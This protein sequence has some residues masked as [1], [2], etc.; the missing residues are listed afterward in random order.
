[1]KVRSKTFDCAVVFLN[2]LITNKKVNA[3]ILANQTDSD[4][5]TAKRAIQYVK[6]MIIELDLNLQFWFDYKSNSTRYFLH[7]PYEIE[8]LQTLSYKALSKYLP[9]IVMLKLLFNQKVNYKE[10]SQD[11][12]KC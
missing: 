2:Q 5:R 9:L 4:V 6:E 7:T 8:F 12:Y 1:M 11:G 10:L 3:T